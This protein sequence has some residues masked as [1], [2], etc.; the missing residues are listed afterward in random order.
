MMIRRRTCMATALSAMVALSACEE[1]DWENPEYVGKMILDEDALTARTA[2]EKVG[3]L[4]DEDAKKVLPQLIEVYKRDGLNQKEAMQYI[5]QF[6]DPS[7][8]EVYLAE[9]ETDITGY[10]RASAEALGEV[11][12]EDAVPKMLEILAKTDKDE[13]KLGIVQAFQHMP[14]PAMVEPLIGILKLDVDSNPIQLLAHACEALGHLGEVNPEAVQP[15][16]KQM[17]LAVFYGNMTGQSLDLDCGQALQTIGQPA[18]PELIAIFKGE[19]EDV[20]KLMMKYDTPQAAFP[21]NSPQLI[22]AKRLASLRAKEAIPV[23]VEWLS[24]KHEAP[25]DLKDRKAVNWRVKEAQVMSEVIR[26][27]GDLGAQEAVPLLEETV[28]GKRINEDIW[29]DV[30]DWQVELQLRQDAGFALNAMGNRGSVPIL[31]EMADKGVVNDMEKVMAQN[32]A[33]GNKPNDV[34]RYQ[35]NWMSLRTAAMLSTGADLDKFQAITTKNGEKYPD[36]SKKMGEFIPVVQQA[37]TCNA[38]ADDAKKAACYGGKLADNRPELREK[39]A[40][41]LSRLPKEAALPVILENIGT[42]FLDTREILTFGLYRHADASSVEALNKLLEEEKDKG[43]GDYRLD[44]Y[45]LK[46]ARAWLKNNT[47]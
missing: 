25:E 14:T 40:W 46:L 32:E 39:A 33:A 6:R 17:T 26:S 4:S 3:D 31:L 11:K 42:D 29:T 10:A 35:F 28:Q 19:R 20:Q 30:T 47:K 34:T 8:K 24:G 15:A 18:V 36:L 45:R 41:E 9:L 13:V 38:E 27:L 16:V 7:A 2:I 23:F 44:R 37:Q 43:G 5:V 1:A 12:A 22:A 21:Q